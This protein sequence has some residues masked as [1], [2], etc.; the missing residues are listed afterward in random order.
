MPGDICHPEE[1]LPTAQMVGKILSVLR[2][3]GISPAQ[4]SRPS[5]INLIGEKPVKRN[6]LLGQTMLWLS[7]AMIVYV[8]FFV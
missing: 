4:I 3:V 8:L 6:N 2:F 7:I 5:P 1:D